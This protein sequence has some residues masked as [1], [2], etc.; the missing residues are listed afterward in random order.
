MDV[1]LNSTP[2]L[3][4]VGLDPSARFSSRNLP[5]LRI[6]PANEICAQRMMRP[7]ALAAVSRARAYLHCGAKMNV[8]ASLTNR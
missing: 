8:G 4:P 6:L 2:M 5:E 3:P 1:I 7:L